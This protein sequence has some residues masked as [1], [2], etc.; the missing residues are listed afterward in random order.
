M[1]GALAL[2]LAAASLGM[3]RN[4]PQARNPPTE[5]VMEWKGVNCGISRQRAVLVTN[6]SDWTQLWKDAFGKDAP[7]AEFKNRFAVAV[8][9][10]A[11]PTGGWTPQLSE[12]ASPDDTTRILGWRVAPP[13]P[14]AFVIQAFTQPYLIQLLDGDPSK[15]ELR[16][17]D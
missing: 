7:A 4:P 2:I 1:R 14:G 12:L 5:A 3:A 11:E 9:A 10:G 6:E 16:P 17:L 8:F 15:V 13:P